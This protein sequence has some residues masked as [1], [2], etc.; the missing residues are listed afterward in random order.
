M[1][2]LPIPVHVGS[3]PPDYWDDVEARQRLYAEEASQRLLDMRRPALASPEVDWD[4]L[5]FEP[6][7]VGFNTADCVAAL[8]P[9]IFSGH[10]ADEFDRFRQGAASRGELAL[11]ISPIGSREAKATWNVFHGHDDS[12][13]IGNLEG[14]IYGRPLGK[15]VNVLPAEQIGG[16]DRDL[17]LR[18]I[19]CSPPLTWRSLSLHGVTLE[20]INGTQHHP[21]QGTLLPIAETELGEPVVAV[22]VSPDEIERRYIVPVETPWPVLLRWLLERALPEYVP[23]AIRRARRPL[24][25]DE[26]LMTRRERTARTSLMDFEARYQAQRADL[27]HELEEAQ[28]AAS[29]TREGLLYGTGRPLADNVRSVLESAGM[30]VVDLDVELGGTKNAD[31]LCTY[32]GRSR[33]VEVKSASGNASESFYDD[34]IGHLREWQHLSGTTPVEGGALVINH[35]HRIPPNERKPKLYGRPEFLAAQTEPV[36]ST[37]QLFNAWRDEQWEVVRGLLFGDATS[38]QVSG[39][40]EQ[41][42]PGEPAAPDPGPPSGSSDRRRGWRRRR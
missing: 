7:W 29:G 18:L 3:E 11:V 10:G 25:N 31:L 19:N 30:T 41:A 6:R 4:V 15:G 14:A 42:E 37:I 26:M 8:Q 34:L 24:A 17:A 9:S 27:Q 38:T 28:A 22:W 32:G 33:L 13:S 20:G 35:Q 36:I 39:E 5:G 40:V 12:V 2:R 1:T 23:N 21:A 16:A